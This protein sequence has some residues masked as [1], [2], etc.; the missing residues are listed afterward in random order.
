MATVEQVLYKKERQDKAKQR[1]G[2]EKEREGKALI[3][4]F[5]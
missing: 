1:Q 4:I 2:K 3:Q 5:S